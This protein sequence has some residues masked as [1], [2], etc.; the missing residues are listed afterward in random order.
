[1]SELQNTVTIDL[2]EYRE[3]VVSE[4][5]NGKLKKTIAQEIKE[6][7]KERIDL[8]IQKNNLKDT[9]AE[10]KTDVLKGF[11]NKNFYYGDR[12]SQVKYLTKKTG[13]TSYPY[14][15][16]EDVETLQRLGFKIKDLENHIN[17]MW[18]QREKEKEEAKKVKE[19]SKEWKDY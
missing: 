8:V 1:M 2:Q 12:E 6:L 11:S 19:E 4:Y 9:L 17:I 7:E 13:Y 15:D 5:E 16:D 18:E 10:N 3:F 14:F